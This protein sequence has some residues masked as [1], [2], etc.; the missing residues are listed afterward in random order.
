MHPGIYWSRQVFGL[1]LD[2]PLAPEFGEGQKKLIPSVFCHGNMTSAEGHYGIPMIMAS[3]GYI[4]FS[5]TFMDGSAPYCKDKEGQDIF[6]K[7]FQGSDKPLLPDGSPNLE[8][9]AKLAPM[10]EQRK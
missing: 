1:C 8:M 10:I 4:V 3:H 5:I 6:Y 2:A 9:H 7:D